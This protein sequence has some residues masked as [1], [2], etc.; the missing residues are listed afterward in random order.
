MTGFAA[1]L[2]PEPGNAATAAR[3]AALGVSVRRLPLF[4]YAPLAWTPPDPAAFDALLLTSAAA[5]RLAG[6]GLARLAH[7]P[8]AAVGAATARAAREAGL[9]VAMVGAGDAAAAVAGAR[10]RG[11]H[12]LLHLAGRDRTAG[13]VPA[14]AVYAAEAAP[15]APGAVRALEGG[16]ALL[17]SPRAARRLAAATAEDGADRARIALA[18][19]SPAVLAAAG[20]GWRAAVAAERPD[21]GALCRLAAA[22]VAAWGSSARD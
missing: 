13:D 6:P 14:L 16:V 4:R 11:W 12:R 7:L 21:D 15:L 22:M 2:R 5:A 10:T 9:S 19:L 3:L 17:H 1:V 8:V 20:P 18:A